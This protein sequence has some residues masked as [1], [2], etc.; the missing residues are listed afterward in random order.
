MRYFCCDRF[1]RN[2]VD[3]H[4]TLNA[5]D[6][7]EVA[8]LAP[9][10]LDAAELAEYNAL[11][12][13]ERDRLL[14]QRKLTLHFVNPLTPQHVAGL[15]P[16]TIRITGGERIRDIRIDV[17][18]L[19]A[20][21]AALRAAVA[22]DH[23]R[24]RLALVRSASDPRPPQDFDPILSTVE[25]SF[26]VDCPSE[27]DCRPAVACPAVPEPAPE[28]DYLAK[29]YASFR[30]LVL[31][32]MAQLV[33]DWRERSPADLGVAL[34]ELLAY[35]GDHLSYQQDAVATE[36]YLDTA[37][38][39]TSVR[40][41]A[42]LVDYFVHDGCN[43]RAWLHV[44]VNDDT[45]V[46]APGALKCFTRLEGLAA[47][48][49]PDA[50]EV[51]HALDAGVE[52]F[53]PVVPALDPDTPVA[54]LVF[55]AD[56]NALRF[57]TWG[58][59]R[60]CLPRGATRATLR[61]HRPHLAPGTVLVF[62]EVKGPLTGVAG[63]ADPAKRHA[64]RLTRV[65]HT[66]DGAPL[67][68]PLDGTA[69]TA[70]EWGSADALPFPLCIS[71]RTE[72]GDAPVADVSVARGNIV[73]VD[74]GRSVTQALGAVPAPRLYLAFDADQAHCARPPRVA[75]PPRF[76][77]ALAEAP[78]TRTGT[79]AKRIETPAGAETVRVRF[80][81]DAPARDAFVFEMREVRP[82]IAVTS[83][84]P[85]ATIDWLPARDLLSSAR[86]TPAF[87]VET[88]H[89]GATRLRFGDGE[90]GLRPPSGAEVEAAYR[91]GNGAAGNVGADA[92]VHAVTLDARIVAV[93]NPLPARGGR[94][95]ESVEQV[96]RR[97]P[98]AF[99]TQERAVTPA[100]YEAVAVRHPEVQ[101]AA[102]T[103]RWTGSWHTVFLTVDPFGGRPLDTDL[104]GALA[105]HVERYRM[106]GHDLEFDAP[107]FV[108]LELELFVCVAP[109]YFRSD[110]KARLLEVLSSRTFP[111]GRR[112]LF[113][114]DNF[115]FGQT[116]Y[117]SPILAAVRDV[118]GVAS[119]NVV[120]F[121][122]QGTDTRRYI[123]DGKLPLGRLEVAQ[124]ENDPNFP[125]RGV[126]RIELGGGK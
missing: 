16:Q 117:L 103:L 15:S 84:Q 36:A 34:A 113:H 43:A 124:L 85:D 1:R 20:D 35:V 22:G 106:A 99:R 28:I 108:P 12:A 112:G 109:E 101:R 76:R 72:A 79:V 104:E 123:D 13:N 32:R 102:A 26:K 74:H 56:H 49:V 83:T 46:L 29:D 53:E 60:C 115:T 64:V 126:V 69:I 67:V 62:E 119:A 40:R 18:A 80:D 95:P 65:V 75:V 125:E 86:T 88:E 41:H 21:A 68:D 5:I 70:I 91:V 38:L 2:A 111:D 116:I 71:S 4:A 3:A 54:P 44:A 97:A 51:G 98:Q 61:E 90:H 19:G 24:Y 107:R 50:P 100:D 92:I 17:L 37:R 77:P 73:L 55:H 8:D 122:R 39:R 93:R 27:F 57:Y 42:L 87:V 48:L 120:K 89:D 47:R 94:D 59:E 66:E 30:R 10:E 63:D 52:W 121:Q 58:D 11:P 81:P 45:V 96:R 6:Y 33:P 78:L 9:T 31:D 82:S 105:R 7:L 110:V 118:A 23:S 25:F 114:P 14:W